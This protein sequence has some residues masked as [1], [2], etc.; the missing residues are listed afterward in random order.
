MLY[1]KCLNASCPDLE[2]LVRYSSLEQTPQTPTCNGCNTEYGVQVEYEPKIFQ[3][4]E[5]H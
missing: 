4:L 2:Y 1:Y 5:S 3:K